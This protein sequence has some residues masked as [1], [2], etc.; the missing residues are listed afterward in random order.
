MQP[1]LSTSY[2]RFIDLYF[3][4]FDKF[5]RNNKDIRWFS[6]FNV[7]VQFLPR[8]FLDIFWILNLCSS[9]MN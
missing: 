1:S 8:A 2:H 4:L 7:S 6:F 9:R 5:G 3:A